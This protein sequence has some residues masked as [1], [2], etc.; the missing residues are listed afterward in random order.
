MHQEQAEKPREETT[1]YLEAPSDEPIPPDPNGDETAALHG[2]TDQLSA[3]VPQFHAEANSLQQTI[4]QQQ[5]TI[6]EQAQR[7]AELEAELAAGGGGTTITASVA[8]GVLT[9][10]WKDIEPAMPKDWVALYPIGT[11][12]F[13]DWL[14]VNNS[15]QAGVAVPSG[16]VYWYTTG[17]AG[18]YDVKL[19]ANDGPNVLAQ[20]MVTI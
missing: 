16:S 4:D 6:D 5:T 7:I 12:N 10:T 11:S 2:L 9:R 17:L 14:Y 3:L 19:C 13:T 18:S 20:C 15:K 8:N 1:F